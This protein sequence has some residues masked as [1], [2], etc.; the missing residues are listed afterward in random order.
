[1]THSVCLDNIFFPYTIDIYYAT[2]TQDAWGTMNST[3]TFNRTVPCLAINTYEHKTLTSPMLL[4][5]KFEL[6][7]DSYQIHTNQNILHDEATDTWYTPQQT[8]LTN[9]SVEAESKYWRGMGNENGGTPVKF[10]I[11]G[12]IPVLDPFGNLFNYKILAFISNDQ[13]QALS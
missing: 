5:D 10:E 13:N 11:R 12:V 1:M 6:W 8:L 3:W 9:L 2:H 4:E 7:H